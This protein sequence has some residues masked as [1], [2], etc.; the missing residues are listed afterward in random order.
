LARICSAIGSGAGPVRD[1]S[2]AVNGALL[3]GIADG[4]A[5]GIAAGDVAGF[6]VTYLYW[7]EGGEVSGRFVGT[8]TDGAALAG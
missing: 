4:A 3:A 7:V 8:E 1:A 6:A 5:A 2:G